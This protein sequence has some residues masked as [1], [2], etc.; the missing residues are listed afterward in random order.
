MTISSL[1]ITPSKWLSDLIE[2]T[3]R[4]I[5]AQSESVTEKVDETVLVD[6]LPETLVA[7][8]QYCIL[9]PLSTR[10]EVFQLIYNGRG[11]LFR[12]AKDM[13]PPEP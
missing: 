6:A 13:C 7:S 10:A 5:H 12:I 4:A 3:D 8:V 2:V 1:A 9:C 11:D